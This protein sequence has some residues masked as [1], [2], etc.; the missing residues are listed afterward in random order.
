[1]MTVTDYS[2]VQM[3]KCVMTVTDYNGVQMGKL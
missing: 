3:G 2:D 1:M